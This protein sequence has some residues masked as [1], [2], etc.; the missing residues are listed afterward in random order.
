MAASG[1]EP[2]CPRCG[3]GDCLP[4]TLE[5]DPDAAEIPLQITGL[6]KAYRN[7]HL[8]VDGVTFQVETSPKGPRAARVRAGN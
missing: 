7:G 1:T 3:S 8:A 5:Y 4:F 2:S 6:T